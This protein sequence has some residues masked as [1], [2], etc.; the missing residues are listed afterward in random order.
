MLHRPPSVEHD[1]PRRSPYKEEFIAPAAGSAVS[2]QPSRIALAAESHCA[3]GRARGRGE[4]CT[5][6]DSLRGYKGSAF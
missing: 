3:Q 2:G 4:W 1:V 5:F 6:N